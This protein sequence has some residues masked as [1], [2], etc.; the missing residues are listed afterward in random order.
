MSSTRLV[1]AHAV[2]HLIAPERFGAAPRLPAPGRRDLR[3]QAERARQRRVPPDDSDIPRSLNPSARVGLE[4]Q[5]ELAGGPRADQLAPRPGPAQRGRCSPPAASGTRGTVRRHR[6]DRCPERTLPL[7]ETGICACSP[8]LSVATP[9]AVMVASDRRPR[10][11]DPV[12]SD[13]SRPVAMSP[14]QPWDDEHP[15]SV[16]RRKIAAATGPYRE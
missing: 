13:H 9:V 2:G 6:A 10:H 16:M 8:K 11:H 7:S 12:G 14:L 1:R 5:C 15:C 3:G 4:R